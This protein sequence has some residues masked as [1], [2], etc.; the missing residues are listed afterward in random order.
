MPN[1]QTALPATV[2][3]ETW[4]APVIANRGNIIWA[5]VMNATTIGGVCPIDR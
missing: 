5:N 1:R 4:Y 2:W 3:L